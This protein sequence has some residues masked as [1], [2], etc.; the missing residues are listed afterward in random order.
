MR[1]S[2]YTGPG[3]FVGTHRP[4]CLGTT[5]TMKLLL[6]VL[7]TILLT[8]YS[9][10]ITKWRVAALAASSASSTSVTERAFTYLLDPFI[11]S[12]YIFALLSSVAWLFVVERHPV[13]IAFPA[14]VGAMFALVTIGSGL[15][16]KEAIS[17][18]QILGL[19][20]IFVGV[21]V[22]SRAG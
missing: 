14:Y 13:S 8:T 6:A 4:T 20:I 17:I 1:P 16:L 15:W 9:Q 11:V 22:V 5:D 12:A 10:L 19:S 21:V 7:P 18:Q 3:C 2:L